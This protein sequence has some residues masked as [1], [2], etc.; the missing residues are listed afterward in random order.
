MTG[1]HHQTFS[2]HLVPRTWDIIIDGRTAAVLRVNRSAPSATDFV[3]RLKLYATDGQLDEQLEEDVQVESWDG[4]NLS[5]VRRAS[6]AQER[7]TG[8][9]SGRMIAGSSSAA[10][11]SATAE[12]AQPWTGHR[13][14]V[15]THGVGAKSAATV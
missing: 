11:G 2:R 13:I 4:V 7:F 15:L 14:E 10:V 1:W 5:F 8:T 6:P 9:A 12:A 3:G